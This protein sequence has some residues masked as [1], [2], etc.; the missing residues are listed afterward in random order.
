LTQ[1]VAPM[2][3]W[4]EGIYSPRKSINIAPCK[5]FPGIYNCRFSIVEAM[6]EVFIWTVSNSLFQMMIYAFLSLDVTVFKIHTGHTQY[7]V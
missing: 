5:I 3:S 1:V 7:V 4:W 2:G 6:S